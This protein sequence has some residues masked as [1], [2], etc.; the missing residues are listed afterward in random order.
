MKAIRLIDTG[1]QTYVTCLRLVNGKLWWKIRTRTLKTPGDTLRILQNKSL[2]LEILV[3]LKRINPALK[4]KEF[5][6]IFKNGDFSSTSS[7]FII[8]NHFK[9]YS[10]PMALNET[11]ILI[12]H[13]FKNKKC[14]EFVKSLDSVGDLVFMEHSDEYSTLYDVMLKEKYP[15]KGKPQHD[16]YVRYIKNDF[17]TGRKH[18]VFSI[19]QIDDDIEFEIIDA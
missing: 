3:S 2:N 14:F 18:Y 9:I 7:Q 4:S 1:Y 11:I 19:D 12:S 17:N 15:F 6:F 5:V 13:L 8:R 10:N 16:I